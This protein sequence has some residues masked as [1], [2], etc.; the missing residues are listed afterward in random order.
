MS[1]EVVFNHSHLRT[2]TRHIKLVQDA[3]Q[4]LGER[5]IESGETK[6]GLTLIANGLRHD[7]SKFKGVEW[8]FLV[9]VAEDDEVAKE[10]LTIAWRQHVESN[11]HH[12][13]YWESI[14]EMPRIFIAEMVCDWFARSQEMGTDLRAWIK[15]TAS[16]KYE[17]SLKGKAYKQV[18]YFVDMLLDPQFKPIKPTS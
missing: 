4:L 11:E 16:A 15:E 7:Q 14:N 9:R 10:H 18:K 5:L 6:F 12:P 1:E 3:T 17:M 2:V 8:D 13:E